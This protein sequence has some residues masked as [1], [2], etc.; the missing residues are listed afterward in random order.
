[1]VKDSDDSEV[2]FRL[3]KYEEVQAIISFRLVLGSSP[4]PASNCH[5]KFTANSPTIR[6]HLALVS[7]TDW[8]SVA[9]Q[10]PRKV[11]KVGLSPQDDDIIFG[12]DGR[13]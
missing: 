7:D 13:P 2:S 5:Q 11:Y 6:L 10:C 4:R 3:I 1:M 8:W 9:T 12:A